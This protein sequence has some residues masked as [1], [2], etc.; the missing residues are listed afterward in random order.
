MTRDVRNYRREL[1]VCHG[2]GTSVT[3]QVRYRD[4]HSKERP[5][6]SG[7]GGQ[8]AASFESWKRYAE[9]RNLSVDLL[10]A[11][12]QTHIL[13]KLLGASRLGAG[14]PNRSPAC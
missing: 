11:R 12:N 14:P 13:A 8:A 9:T 3:F 1:N 10:P 5:R 6:W 2:R 4:S 7:A